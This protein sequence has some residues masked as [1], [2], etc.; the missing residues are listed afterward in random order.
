MAVS[1]QRVID[2]L[3]GKSFLALSRVQVYIARLR[4]EPVGSMDLFSLNY[5]SPLEPTAS[6]SLSFLLLILIHYYLH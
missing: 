5:K 6:K 4:A 3:V 2:S 1:C